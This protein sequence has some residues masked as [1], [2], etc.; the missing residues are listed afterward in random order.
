M[1]ITI[2]TILM[3]FTSALAENFACFSEF[4]QSGLSERSGLDSD[5]LILLSDRKIFGKPKYSIITTNNNL[6]TSNHSNYEM[7]TN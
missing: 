2:I 5:S 1:Q 3:I 7:E 4:M 6:L